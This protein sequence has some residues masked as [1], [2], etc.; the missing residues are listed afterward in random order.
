MKEKAGGITWFSY[1]FTYG[2][3]S[4]GLTKWAWSWFVHFS[5]GGCMYQWCWLVQWVTKLL[6]ALAGTVD[7]RLQNDQW[8][9]LVRWIADY[10]IANGVGWYSGV[11]I[12]K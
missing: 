3:G 6:M 7:C 9:W 4:N 8:S 2:V 12:T 11:W 5:Y 10:K 1:Y